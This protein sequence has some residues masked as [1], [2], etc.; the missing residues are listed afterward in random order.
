MLSCN[1]ALGRRSAIGS[2]LGSGIGPGA[3][4]QLEIANGR[5]RCIAAVGAASRDG[6]E[7]GGTGRWLHAGLCDRSGS[8]RLG[9]RR[10]PLGLK[11][12][13]TE[14]APSPGW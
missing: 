11:G 12:I 9:A 8:A 7:C 4:V 10:S 6:P 3:D 2:F 14:S 5:N 1:R 13:S